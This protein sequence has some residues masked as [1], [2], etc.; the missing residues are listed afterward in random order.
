MP[1]PS[2][3]LP[4]TVQA[5]TVL[6]TNGEWGAYTS[7]NS[8]HYGLISHLTT[9]AFALE[10]ITVEW[11]FFPWERAFSLVERGEYAG[12]TGWGKTP[13]KEEVVMFLP[14]S[15]METCD[16]FYYRQGYDFDWKTVDDLEGHRIGL[17]LAYYTVD[18]FEAFIEEGKPLTIDIVDDQTTNIEKLLL[19]RI[20]VAI[21]DKQVGQKTLQENFS[22]EEVALITTHP[23]P[24]NCSGAYVIIDKQ[25]PQ[26]E[27]LAQSF[28]RGLQQLK[29]SGRYD[30]MM[31]DFVNGV[32]DN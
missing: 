31:T 17:M 1:T 21:M 29:D 2:P 10:G 14:T 20:D 7:E 30:Q 27:Q 13:E 25:N 22:P 11:D 24:W 9:E 12:S 32:Y 26:A 4:A 15:V 23:T 3:T 16:V 28:E 5:N 18:Q 19:E 8:A 6:F